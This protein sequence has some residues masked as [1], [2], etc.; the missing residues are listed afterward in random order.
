MEYL[1]DF[2][3]VVYKTMTALFTAYRRMKRN[4]NASKVAESFFSA[5]IIAISLIALQNHEEHLSDLISIVTII[6]STFLLVMSLLF[7]GLD[8]EKRMDNYH[9]CGN[10]LDKLYRD[11]KLILSYG[12]EISSDEMKAKTED[13]QAKYFDILHKYNLNH[14]SFDY[15]YTAVMLDEQKDFVSRLVM[16]FRYYVWDMYFLYWVIALLPVVLIGWYLCR[17]LLENLSE[18]S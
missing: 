2:S 15:E 7:S 6:L 8:Y 3:D 17:L 5:S 10:E 18:R 16:K 1:K 14:T 11:M 9:D 13:F 4:R 12:E